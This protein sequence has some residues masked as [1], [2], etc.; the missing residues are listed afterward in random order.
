MESETRQQ[1]RLAFTRHC[2]GSDD[3]K[4]QV[5]SADASFRSY[6][7]VTTTTGSRMLMDAPPDQ[8]DCRPFIDICSRLR[9]ADLLAP[10]II[11]MDLENGLLLLEDF[12]DTL[13]RDRITPDQPE[14][15]FERSFNALATLATRVDT[16]GLSGYDR[17]RL[18]TELDLFPDWYL[19]RQLS[20]PL[21]DG[22]GSVWRAACELLL[23]SA[24]DQPAVF[25]HRDFHSCN[26]M[27]TGDERPGIIDFQDA[28]LGPVSY[29]LISLLLDR[30]ISWPRASL[31]EWLERFRVRLG[32]NLG[33][34]DWLQRC[35]WMALQRNL[36]VVGIFARL[37]FRDGK[38]GYLDLQPR[39]LTFVLDGLSRYP[40][41]AD[42]HALVES[43]Q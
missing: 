12:G 11:E 3:F 37:N 40:E 23:A 18:Q 20:R 31:V 39:F 2:L 14:P 10:E 9:R 25:V 1:Q 41:F 29:D 13:Y 17:Q 19:D 30:Y 35:D 5:A 27:D 21:D 15:W 6:H 38:S 26:L 34:A 36:K 22:E 16:D 28:V 43:R 24:E 32:L 7:R 33:S 8:E 42:L 4:L